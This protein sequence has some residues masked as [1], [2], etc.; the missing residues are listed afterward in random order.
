MSAWAHVF[1]CSSRRKGASSRTRP[2]AKDR[3]AGRSPAVDEDVEKLSD[4]IAARFLLAEDP[5]PLPDSRYKVSM[6]AHRDKTMAPRHTTD[7][8]PPPP[9]HSALHAA[10]P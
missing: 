7:V 2:P 8:S 6:H 1:P 9:A 5:K 10:L 4:M 3:S